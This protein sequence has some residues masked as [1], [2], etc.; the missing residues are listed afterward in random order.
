MRVYSMMNISFLENGA[1]CEIKDC[2]L[3]A[4]VIEKKVSNTPIEFCNILLKKS[5]E[6]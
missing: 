2:N 3:V 4:K 1:N 6:N 5:H